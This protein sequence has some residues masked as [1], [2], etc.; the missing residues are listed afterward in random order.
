MDTERILELS[1]EYNI[2]TANVHELCSQIKKELQEESNREAA[3]AAQRR[4]EQLA[5][6]DE[7]LRAG[8]TALSIRLRRDAYQTR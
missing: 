7:A 6:A 8:D 3:Q 4:G 2:H 1:K 5:R